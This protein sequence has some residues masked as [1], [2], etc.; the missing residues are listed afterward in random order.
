ME[1]ATEP[2]PRLQAIVAALSHNR[3]E[4]DAA[5]LARLLR[6]LETSAPAK[7]AAG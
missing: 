4:M 1:T 2:D 5:T 7:V 6:L 3:G